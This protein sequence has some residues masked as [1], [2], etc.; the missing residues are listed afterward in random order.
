MTDYPHG[1]NNSWKKQEDARKWRGLLGIFVTVVLLFAAANGIAKTLSIGKFFGSSSWDAKSTFSTVVTTSPLSVLV[2]NPTSDE[3]ALV[4]FKEDLYFATGDQNEPL[5]EIGKISSA[6]TGTDLSKA[7]SRIT[8]SPIAN[9]VV[10]E[11][12]KEASLEGLRAYFKSFASL[13]TP[14]KIMLSKPAGVSSTN[15][16]RIDMIRLWWQIKSLSINNLNFIDAAGFTEEIVMTGGYKVLGVDDASLH[17]LMSQ[18]LQNWTILEEGLAIS[19]EDFST[20][21]TSGDLARD[22]V[23]AVGGQ[24][25]G[26]SYKRGENLEKTI[27]LAGRDSYTASYLAKIFGCDIKSLPDLAESEIKV[28][29]GRDFGQKF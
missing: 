6:A 18:Y 23:M 1:R 22:F 9:F 4:K 2:Y 28:I 10:L 7:A 11:E 20:D 21:P 24:V 15:I 26:V 25:T 29:L 27:I 5:A 8:R 17:R 16:T 13:S 12:T 19:V 3:V 14:V